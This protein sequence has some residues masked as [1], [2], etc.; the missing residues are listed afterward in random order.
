MQ[1]SKIPWCTHTWNPVIGCPLPLASK[2]CANCY[3]RKL[4]NGRHKAYLDGKKIPV[5]YA[6]PFEQI[7]LLPDRLDDPLHCR[8]KD[9][10][11]FVCSMS[12]LFH[13]KVPFDF[14]DK[15]FD[16]IRRTPDH[17]YQ[18]LTKY[19]KRMADFIYLAYGVNHKLGNAWLGTSISTQPDADK[20]IPILLQIPAAVRSISL[21]P[22]L[23]TIQDNCKGFPRPQ[24]PFNRKMVGGWFWEELDW[25]IIGCESG[26]RARLCFIDNIHAVVK[27][28]RAAGVPV[29]VKQ[30]PVNSKCN[31][32]PD[33]W[34]ED[35]RVQ[36]YPK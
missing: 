7:Q 19:P 8:A 13:P 26:P 23:E 2:G 4:H 36:E 34:P 31:K 11:I 6:K 33:E 18:I 15:V 20:N 32:N 9:A 21:E 22:I 28:C 35:L 12:D 5:Q 27:Q 25:V 10:K 24:I 30:I 29:F 1:K 16:V 14:I 17:T 3:A